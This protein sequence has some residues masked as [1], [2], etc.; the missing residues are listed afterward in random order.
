MTLERLIH[1]CARCLSL[2]ARMDESHGDSWINRHDPQRKG[3]RSLSVH[4]CSF[5]WCCSSTVNRSAHSAL[6]SV[7]AFTLAT[8]LSSLSFGRVAGSRMVNRSMR[9][10]AT[11]RTTSHRCQ[12]FIG[13]LAIAA[14]CWALSCLSYA[15]LSSASPRILL[16]P[17]GLA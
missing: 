11:S 4:R 9:N 17:E 1:L 3:A 7:N 2:G 12:S 5:P 16:N 8:R 13:G 15:P 10:T 14:L 6:M